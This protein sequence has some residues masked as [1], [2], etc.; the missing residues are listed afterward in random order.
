V[1]LVAEDRDD[2][3]YY[4]VILQG[5]GYRVRGCESYEEGLRLLCTERFDCIIVS[6]GSLNFEGRCVLERANQIDQHLPVLVVARC[7]DMRCYLDAMQLGAVDYLAEPLAV[8]ELGR[9]VETH[10]RLRTA[11]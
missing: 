4:G 5:L 8:E 9:A 2:L 6:Q 7:L 1:L 11:A 10:L 3:H